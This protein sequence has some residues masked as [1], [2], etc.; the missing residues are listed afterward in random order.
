MDK[1]FIIY[2]IWAVIAIS[3]SFLNSGPSP[4]TITHTLIIGFIGIQIALF[5][6]LEKLKKSFSPKKLFFIISLISA[7]AVEGFYMISNPVFR[8]LQITSSTSLFQI[9]PNYLID[10]LF[11]FPA[12]VIVFLVIWH[13][14]NKYK[15]K[16]WEYIIFI[17]LGQALGDGGAYFFT[18]PFMLIFIPYIMLNYHAM[19]STGYFLIKQELNPKNNSRLKYIIPPLCIIIAYLICGATIKLIGQ[20]IGLV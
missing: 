4:D 17:G 2:L 3:I 11:T 7:C 8:N 5:P 6:R 18:N 20:S 10:L 1:P 19:N 9:L 14:I 15:Y 13:F 16:N 12:Y